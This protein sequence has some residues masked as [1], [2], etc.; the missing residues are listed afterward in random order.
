MSRGLGAMQR[1][2]LRAYDASLASPPSAWDARHGWRDYAWLRIEVARLRGVWCTTYCWGPG[3]RLAS[4]RPHTP[5]GGAF[6]VAYAR[7]VRTLIRRGILVAVT[8][9]DEPCRVL[10]FDHIQAV[11]RAK[12]SEK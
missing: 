4:H 10:S 1:E 5:Y 12:C 9:Q 8:F 11:E 7:A 6:D 2:I 3:L